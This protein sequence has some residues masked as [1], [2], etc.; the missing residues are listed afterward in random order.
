MAPSILPEVKDALP[1]DLCSCQVVVDIQKSEPHT[2]GLRSLTCPELARNFNVL[3]RCIPRV[4]FSLAMSV[5]KFDG[6]GVK[7]FQASL[8]K[9]G[10][11]L[12]VVDFYADWCGE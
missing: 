5:Q 12:V 7:E 1:A 4:T 9:A 10:G 8:S 11:R 2:K 6:S 3:P